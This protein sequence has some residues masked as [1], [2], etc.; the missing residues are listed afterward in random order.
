[1]VLTDNQLGMIEQLTYL[2]S[3]VASEAGISDFT[4]IKA[5]QENMTIS[6]ILGCFDEKALATLE[7]KGDAT[8]GFSSAKEWAGIIRY[9]KSS[10]M[11][12]LVLTGTMKDSKGTTLALCFSEENDVSNAI[13]AF[14]GSTKKEWA[15]NIEGLNVA[16]T[17]RQLEAREYIESLPYDNIT[18]TG[19]SKG[20]N[21]AMYVAVTSDKVTRCVAYDGQGYSQ[22]FINKYGPEIINKAGIITAYSVSTDYVH[23]LLFPIPG[24]EQI[25]CQGFGISNTREHHSPSS[26]FMTDDSGNIEVDA[27]GNPIIIET[28]EDE[29]I[30]MLH[31][32]T[33]FVLN[34]ASDEEKKKITGYLCPL[35]EKAFSKEKITVDEILADQDTLA[36]IIAYLA[37][38]MQVSGRSTEDIEQ[39]LQ[40]IGFGELNSFLTLKEFNALGNTYKINFNLSYLISQLIDEDDD[41]FYKRTLSFLKELFTDKYD[42]NVHKF[43]D[44]INSNVKRIDASGG[45]GDAKVIGTFDGFITNAYTTMH[46]Y[47]RVN[48]ATLRGYA[49]RLSK[50]N[51]RISSLDRR[52][53][54]LYL[55]VGLRD[56]WNL[57]RADLMTGYSERIANCSKYLDETADDLDTVERNITTKFKE[58]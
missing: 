46:P 19:H 12:D 49:D 4:S 31:E 50:V 56:L 15:D 35:I 36:L 47:I 13:V 10:E 54:S 34:N 45:Y 27:D 29:S 3:S 51:Q 32:F 26:F 25:Y 6:E 24:S 14:K 33:A 39:L 8:I 44:K 22:E 1:M 7:S 52:M 43:W 2:N 28:E 40:T 58:V 53:D 23:A 18:V 5:G 42:I 11:K 38:Y 37:K 9:L 17:P 21:K 16:D 30:K 55:K 57:L 20:A 48:T 41:F